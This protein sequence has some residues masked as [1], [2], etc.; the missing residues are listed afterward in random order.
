MFWNLIDR[1][2]RAQL[3]KLREILERAATPP[4]PGGEFASPK[5]FDFLCK[6]RWMKNAATHFGSGWVAAPYHL[7]TP[8]YLSSLQNPPSVDIVFGKGRFIVTVNGTSRVDVD[9]IARSASPNRGLVAL[10]AKRESDQA[11]VLAGAWT[12]WR[13]FPR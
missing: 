6:A 1:P 7:G 5:D 12:I 13:I 4:D 2:V 10:A 11:I 3:R 9:R 8:A